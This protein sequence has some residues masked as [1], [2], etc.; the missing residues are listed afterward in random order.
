MSPCILHI[1][2]R[3]RRKKFP[4]HRSHSVSG[5]GFWNCIYLFIYYH[6]S[7]WGGI[8]S[9]V[10]VEEACCEAHIYPLENCSFQLMYLNIA[11]HKYLLVLDLYVDQSSKKGWIVSCH[12]PC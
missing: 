12:N 11:F 6:W 8:G 2:K 3:K 1:I 7:A 5:R 4:A 10:L 9:V